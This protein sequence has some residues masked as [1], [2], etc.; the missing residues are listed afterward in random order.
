MCLVHLIYITH[1][2]KCNTFF[3]V[4]PLGKS[5]GHYPSA[6]RVSLSL[7]LSLAFSSR[8]VCLFSTLPAELLWWSATGNEP[9]PDHKEGRRHAMC[10]VRSV[11]VWSC[12]SNM[13]HY[14]MLNIH[15]YNPLFTML[16]PCAGGFKGGRRSSW[17]HDWMNEV[18]LRACL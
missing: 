15:Q 14:V 9:C 13:V 1:S 17:K 2:G 11:W 6:S 5:T 10:E 12:L 16:F 18:W 8:V 4:P 7:N 3:V